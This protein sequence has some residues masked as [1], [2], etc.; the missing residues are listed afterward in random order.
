MKADFKHILYGVIT[1]RTNGRKQSGKE[2]MEL[3]DKAR[4]NSATVMYFPGQAQPSERWYD[5][6]E[7]DK[8]IEMLGKNHKD[9]VLATSTAAM[10]AWMF[11]KYPEVAGDGLCGKAPQVW[12][13]R[14][15]CMPK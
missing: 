14:G 12:T 6:E 5:F 15:K 2:D 10:P 4:I 13:D 3:F 7:L 8:V 11:R 1:T 9:I